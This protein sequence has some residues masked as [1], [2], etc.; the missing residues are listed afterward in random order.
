MVPGKSGAFEAFLKENMSP[1]GGSFNG[2]GGIP[3]V[4]LCVEL[5]SRLC[6]HSLSPGSG[7]F[8]RNICLRTGYVDFDCFGQGL[9][10]SRYLYRPSRG[11]LATSELTL[12]LHCGTVLRDTISLL[13]ASKYF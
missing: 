9:R 11:P 4:S 6:F 13:I 1:G 3:M 5:S 12:A 7:A 10:Q 8:D 2:N